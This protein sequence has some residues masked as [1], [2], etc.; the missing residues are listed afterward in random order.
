M[1]QLMKMNRIEL[2]ACVLLAVLTLPSMAAPPAG[3]AKAGPSKAPHAARVEPAPV[4]PSLS[5]EQIVERNINARGGAAAWQKVQSMTFNGKMDAGRERKDGGVIATNPILTR[6]ESRQR[7]RLILEGKEV[8]EP[9]KVIQ[10][11]F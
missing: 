6:A 11:P 7:G 2:Y 3:A 1:E 8:V 4:L 5:V 9:A 10:L